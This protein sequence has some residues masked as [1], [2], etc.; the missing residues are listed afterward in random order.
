[1]KTVLKYGERRSNGRASFGRLYQFGASPLAAT[2][3]FDSDGDGDTGDDEV[4]A[5][6]K[7]LGKKFKT[8]EEKQGEIIAAMPKD[9]KATCE[10]MT[11]LKMKINDQQANILRMETLIKNFDTQIRNHARNG[12]SNPIQ[13]VQHDPELK[14]R[15][16][17]AV[18]LACSDHNSMLV[19]QKMKDQYKEITGRALGEDAS[20]GSTL[21]NDA[22]ANEI[23]D[24]LS[25][26]GIWNTF[27]VDRLGTKITKYPVTT[28]RPTA[29]FLL[30]EGSSTLSDGSFTGTSVSNEVEVIGALINVSMQIL[31]DSEFDITS[32]VMNHFAES[33]SERMDVA[34]LTADGT[35]NTTFGGMTGVF[36]GGTASVSAT[37]HS[38]ILPSAGSAAT[39]MNFEDVLR[40]LLVVDPIVLARMAKWWM[41]PQVLVRMLGI[42]DGNERPIFLTATEA[43]SPKSIGTI[44]GYPVVPCYAAPSTDTASQ[45]MAVFGDPAGAV[46]GLRSDYVFESSDH[47]RWTTLER[48]FRGWGRFGFKIRK[49]T[50]FAVMTNAA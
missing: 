20:P 15:L 19:T 11:G 27:Q 14:L 25:T 34:C 3:A 1:M 17:I 48:S 28:A 21:I 35:A 38:V 9:L 24:T 8:L 30:S 40:V 46:S 16:N 45:K 18:R 7:S 39:P 43:P 2:M 26:F 49:A 32:F 47:A 10:E 44:L 36:Q 13:R 42:K 37:G 31:Q 6:I 23:Y 12:Y 5:G 22:L 33:Y 29:L 50:A 4:L 41:H